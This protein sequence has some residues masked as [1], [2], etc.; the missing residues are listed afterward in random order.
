M[1]L[2][3]NNETE[4]DDDFYLQLMVKRLLILVLVNQ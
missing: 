4:T 1:S 2:E 3:L